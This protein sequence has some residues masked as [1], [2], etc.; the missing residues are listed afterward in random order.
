MPTWVCEVQRAIFY[1]AIAVETLRVGRVGHE[2]VR[3]DKSAHLRQIVSRIHVDEPYPVTP[4]VVAPVAGEAAVGHRLRRLGA[5]VAE[6]VEARPAAA[7]HDA[8]AAA[9]LGAPE[10]T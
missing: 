4:L 5:P 2:G 10:S 8:A 6:G 3:T 9:R 7:G 1:I